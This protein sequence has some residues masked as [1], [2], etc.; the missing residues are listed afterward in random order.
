MLTPFWK[1]REPTEAEERLSSSATTKPSARE[2]PSARPPESRFSRMCRDRPGSVRS[3]PT[4]QTASFND[5]G[6]GE[7]EAG[8]NIGGAADAVCIISA[9]FAPGFCNY[10]CNRHY[11]AGRAIDL[12]SI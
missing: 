8:G 1:A 12:G 2:V 6:G 10:F 9:N 3:K 5:G 4:K 7:G 11:A